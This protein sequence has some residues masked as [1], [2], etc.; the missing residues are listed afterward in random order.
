MG[1]TTDEI[2]TDIDQRREDLRANIEELETRVKEITD[3]RSYV[4]KHPVPMIVV[5]LLGGV[6]LSSLVGTLGGSRTD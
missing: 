6:V 2:V 1:Q 5:G 4:K 3:W